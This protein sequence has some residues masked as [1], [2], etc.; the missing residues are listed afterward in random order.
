VEQGIAHVCLVLTHGAIDTPTGSLLRASLEQAQ[1]EIGIGTPFLDTSFA[2][3]GFLLTDCLWSTIWSFISSH[4][5]TLSS[6]DQVLL[7]R[8]WHGD[9]FIMERLV[10]LGTLTQ[11]ELISCNRCRLAIE[12]VTLAD[13]TTGNGKRIRDDCLGAHP[14][15]THSSTWDFPV[16]QPCATDKASWRKGL[17][18]ISSATFQWPSE[19]I[20]GPWILTP[21]RRWEWFYLMDDGLLYCHAFNAWHQ[22]TPSSQH[23]TRH[24]TFVHSHIID[25]PPDPMLRATAWIDH[26]GRAHFEG[27]VADVT[28]L[29]PPPATI[30]H[31]I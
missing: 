9:G 20:L 7:H 11:R 16:E 6:P 19:D 15:T 24:R 27:V 13:I 18:A 23:A 10:A 29:S 22:Y 31:L 28:T 12:A 1:L 4:N 14:P 30:H 21:H 26:L 3:Y 5:I 17:A 25:A 8:Q 2:M